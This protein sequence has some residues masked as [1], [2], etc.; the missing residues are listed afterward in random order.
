MEVTEATE[1]PARQSFTEPRPDGYR[2]PS[3]V[4]PRSVPLANAVKVDTPD[5]EITLAPQLIDEAI[6]RIVNRKR[7]AVK[8]LE[9][10]LMKPPPFSMTGQQMGNMPHIVAQREV[11]TQEIERLK[12]DLGNIESMSYEEK[13]DY[14]IQSGTLMIGLSGIYLR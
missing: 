13:R 14:A 5:G 9:A 10:E 4:D 7:E 2:F 6:G 1:I 12:G 3:T 8:A 11:I